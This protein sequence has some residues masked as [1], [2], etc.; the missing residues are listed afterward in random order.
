[1]GTNYYLKVKDPCPTCNRE[2]D[3]GKLH[4]GKSSAGWRFLFF[5]GFA[6]TPAAAFLR[7]RESD[8]KIINEYGE[9]VS[10][11]DLIKLIESKK[12]QDSGS[13]FEHLVEGYRFMSRIF[14]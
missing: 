5:E 9:N 6:K 14:S 10:A 13:E 11:D 7:I 12:D 4:I 8:G 2:F 1:M 3:D